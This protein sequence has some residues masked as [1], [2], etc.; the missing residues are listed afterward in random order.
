M[1][2]FEYILDIINNSQSFYSDD[3]CLQISYSDDPPINLH[4]NKSLYGTNAN[5]ELPGSEQLLLDEL[6]IGTHKGKKKKPRFLDESPLP[7]SLRCFSVKSFNPENRMTKEEMA[8]YIVN[9]LLRE[10]AFG[11]K[12][13]NLLL[14]SEEYGYFQPCKIDSFRGNGLRDLIINLTNNQV[15]KFALDD[16]LLKKVHAI[17]LSKKKISYKLDKQ[18][19]KYVNLRDGVLNLTTGVVEAHHP[20]LHALYYVDANYDPDL[21]MSTAAHDFFWHLADENEEGFKILMQIL[22]LALSNVRRYQ[23]AALIVGPPGCGKSVLTEFIKAVLSKGSVNSVEIESFNKRTDR[24]DLENIQVGICSDFERGVIPA[25]AVAVFKQVVAGETINARHLYQDSKEITPNLFLLFCGN[26][27]PKIEDESG[28]F[29]RRILSIVTGA[30]I[31]EAMRNPNMLDILLSDRDAIIS[32]A[33]RHMINIYNDREQLIR[34]T[35]NLTVKHS[36][37]NLALTS[38]FKERL[39]P[40]KGSYTKIND[41]L[42]DFISYSDIPLPLNGFGMRLKNIGLGLTTRK[43]GGVNCLMDY[44]L[45]DQETPSDD[46]PTDFINQVETSEIK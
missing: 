23:S 22:G 1:T 33:L 30:T 46:S 16:N 39:V 40:C 31:P 6:G 21:E 25:K 44:V 5:S 18:K 28:A 2:S 4:V 3:D 41:L 9:E 17:L 42:V 7:E 32:T 12:D 20:K 29:E 43:K 36:D 8:A 19:E 38:W 27:F 37:P 24:T 13:G 11:V 45:I 34:K 35:L 14:Y 15:N 26:E 10:H